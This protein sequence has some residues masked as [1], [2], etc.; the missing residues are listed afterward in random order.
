MD[1]KIE[2]LEDEIFE[3]KEKIKYS[4]EVEYKEFIIELLFSID[5]ELETP[6]E[7]LSKERILKN[8]KDHIKEFIKNYN[9]FLNI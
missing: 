9:I 6:S 5:K 1:E 7:Y 8:L 4:K 2:K 3:L